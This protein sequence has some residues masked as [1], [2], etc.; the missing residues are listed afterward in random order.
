[1]Q[2]LKRW[3]RVCLVCFSLLAALSVV[4][5]R[6][7]STE[8]KVRETETAAKRVEPYRAH[9]HERPSIDGA[10]TPHLIPDDTAYSLFFGLAASV[11]KGVHD[12]RQ[13]SY[14]RHVLTQ[15]H[16]SGRIRGAY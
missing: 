2:R 12:P 15:A 6:V 11:G 1:M 10:K 16:V 14:V 13:R 5:L 7:Q 4:G 3:H 8:L 9:Q